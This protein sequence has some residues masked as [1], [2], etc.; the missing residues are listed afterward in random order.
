MDEKGD[1]NTVNLMFFQFAGGKTWMI[2]GLFEE[3]YEQ[4]MM[5]GFMAQVDER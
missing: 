5:E 2:N 3:R 4:N 1:T